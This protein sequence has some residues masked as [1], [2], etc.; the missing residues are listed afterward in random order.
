MFT[1]IWKIVLPYVV[2][3]GF[4]ADQLVLS[5]LN[6]EAHLAVQGS[7]NTLPGVPHVESGSAIVTGASVEE[8]RK[9]KLVQ[10][11]QY[12]IIPDGVAERTAEKKSMKEERVAIKDLIK[13]LKETPGKESSEIPTQLEALHLLLSIP[14]FHR[15]LRL[16]GINP[17]FD[18]L[19][20][21]LSTELE[22][23]SHDVGPA[24]ASA[25]LLD[26]VNVQPLSAI[27]G[28]VTRSGG[29]S[30]FLA[31][32]S[33]KNQLKRVKRLKK[34]ITS[35]KSKKEST[36][37]HSFIATPSIL[38]GNPLEL[39]IPQVTNDERLSSEKPF[40]VPGEAQ[41]ST[42]NSPLPA[43]LTISKSPKSETQESQGSSAAFHQNRPMVTTD[44]GITTHQAEISNSPSS[45]KPT[46]LA[47]IPAEAHVT[48]ISGARDLPETEPIPPD[49]ESTSKKSLMSLKEFLI[50]RGIPLG[51]LEIHSDRKGI[52]DGD[53]FEYMKNLIVEEKVKAWESLE[54]RLIELQSLE[55]LPDPTES[56]IEFQLLG[57]LPSP[58]ESGFQLEFLKILFLTGDYIYEYGL[59]PSKFIE[60]IKI[61]KPDLLLNMLK[62]HIDLMFLR[63]GV[64]FF[65]K[66]ETVIPQLEFLTNGL[67]V[68]Q[69]H[70]SIKALTPEYQKRAVYVVLGT[71]MSH[72][73]RY[74]NEDP[75][76]RFSEI[77]EAFCRPQFLEEMQRLSSDLKDGSDTDHLAER[78]N[79]ATVLLIKNVIG[80][81]Q[82]PPWIPVPSHMRIEFLL[83][84]Y[85]LDFL[86]KNYRPVMKTIRS[87][88]GENDFL[89]KNQ[90]K[91]IRSYLKFFQGRAQ[92]PMNFVFE[93]QDHTF[94]QMARSTAPGDVDLRDWILTSPL[95]IFGHTSLRLGAHSPPD[96][97]L[98]MDKIP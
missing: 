29:K 9:V 93:E 58:T 70:R 59:L 77:R 71:I 62:F 20:P 54:T 8:N 3:H 16:S 7:V 67:R 92:D 88:I 79:L 66:S 34:F 94:S 30:K 65:G 6:T 21:K 87:R 53:E 11:K 51:E 35:R 2:L 45:G 76:H 25:D 89:L 84:Y 97:N 23:E 24:I 5:A 55:L 61:F 81:F 27:D 32:I 86:Q 47:S 74:F 85:V 19:L 64:S 78:K 50:G 15:V 18:F 12:G 40:Q 83:G 46:D 37:E 69:F 17:S 26:P 49:Q 1:L 98:W 10:P 60:G 63:W 56:L 13:S 28:R 75:T 22:Q 91:F 43:T 31:H 44:S 72:T 52:L 48:N 14:T 95:A 33:N 68:K 36:R 57:L 38:D 39:T 41:T 4:G 80:F 96:F 73:E 42:S 90:L 82:S